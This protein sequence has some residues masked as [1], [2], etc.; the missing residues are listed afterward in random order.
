MSSMMRT[1]KPGLCW[2]WPERIPSRLP[3]GHLGPPSSVHLA[4]LVGHLSQINYQSSWKGWY[5]MGRQGIPSWQG[6]EPR[7]DQQ[8][9]NQAIPRNV[10]DLLGPLQ[11]FHGN[12]VRT[13]D[14]QIL[15]VSAPSIRSPA[16]AE[17]ETGA[18]ATW[19]CAK[20]G[21]GLDQIWKLLPEMESPISA[22][23]SQA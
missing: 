3:K 17:T 15:P 7:A 2:S 21:F 16:S 9:P 6:G 14:F 8:P 11:S 22:V 10:W 23:G 12:G 13:P 4:P 20:E 1:K 5:N 18:R 19:R